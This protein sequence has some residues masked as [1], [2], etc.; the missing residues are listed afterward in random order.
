[1]GSASEPY[2][3]EVADVPGECS[4]QRGLVA[5]DRGVVGLLY[6]AVGGD[7]LGQQR[8]DYPSTIVAA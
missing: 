1:M 3:D 6:P 4:L 2:D 5:E 7:F 8:L